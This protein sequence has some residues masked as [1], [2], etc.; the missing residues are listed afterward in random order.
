M[1]VKFL[2]NAQVRGVGYFRG[3]VAE[4]DDPTARAYIDAQQCV[5]FVEPVAPRK[6]RDEPQETEDEDDDTDESESKPASRRTA[7]RGGKKVET[8]SKDAGDKR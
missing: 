4:L 3:N 8:A 2:Q 1:L 6:Q 7:R 5:E